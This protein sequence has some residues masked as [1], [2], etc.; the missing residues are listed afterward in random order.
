M[1]SEEDRL[2]TSHVEP[3]DG[4]CLDGG[5]ERQ[6]AESTSRSGLSASG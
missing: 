3:E 2:H 4:H 6:E 5:Q 1:V